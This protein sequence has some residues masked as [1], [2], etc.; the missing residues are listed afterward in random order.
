MLCQKAR[1]FLIV[2]RFVRSPCDLELRLR[3]FRRA[4]IRIDRRAEKEGSVRRVLGVARDLARA[5]KSARRERALG[6][7]RRNSSI[8]LRAMSH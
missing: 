1:R 4:R 3:D 8:V 7:A 6:K 2:L 5:D